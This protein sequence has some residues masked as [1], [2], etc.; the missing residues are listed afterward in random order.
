VKALA[1]LVLLAGVAH[2]QPWAAGVSDKDQGDAQALF[3]DANKLFAQEAHGPALEKYTRAIALWDHPLIRFN[4]AVTL[5]RLDK[6]L[7]AAEAIDRALR[8]G[9]DPFPTPEQY[10]QALDYQKLIAGRVGEIEVTCT[11]RAQVALDGKQWLACPGTQK[12][13]VLAGEHALVAEADGFM[14][15]SQRVIVTGGKTATARVE[16]ER[17]ETAVKYEY[18]TK[19]WIPWSVAGGGAALG[20]V[21]L[22]VYL[23]GKSQM[24]DFKENFARECPRGCDLDTQPALDDQHD[25]ARFKGTLGVTLMITGGAVL[26]GGAVWALVIN[27]PRRVTPAVEVTPAGASI[28]ASWAW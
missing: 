2:A 27:R 19:R 1:I 12:T 21:G 26:A 10:R 22:A 9:K 6:F 5:V 15:K 25:S 11:Q 16:L 4:M 13:R 24:D 7:E 14:T 23:A 8:F 18:P 28:G 20:V 3:A 17:I